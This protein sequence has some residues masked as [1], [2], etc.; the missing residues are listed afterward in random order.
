MNWSACRAAELRLTIWRKLNPLEE[1]DGPQTGSP[2]WQSWIEAE[3][4]KPLGF[5]PR[6]RGMSEEAQE[7]LRSERA[8]RRHCERQDSP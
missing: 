3:L 7:L 8:G 6:F 5:L 2:E 1:G 4:A